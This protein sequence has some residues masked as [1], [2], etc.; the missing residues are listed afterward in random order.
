MN[1]DVKYPKKNY[2]LIGQMIMILNLLSSSSTMLILA[3]ELDTEH[4]GDPKIF[5]V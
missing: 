3:G 1:F 5:H 4:V 2:F